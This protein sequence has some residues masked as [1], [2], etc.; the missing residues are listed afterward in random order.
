DRA[1]E[2]TPSPFT[3]PALTLSESDAALPLEV[4]SLKLGDLAKLLNSAVASPETR[5]FYA[6]FMSKPL[7]RDAW[8]RYPKDKDGLALQKALTKD[9]EFAALFELFSRSDRFQYRL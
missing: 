6:A 8:R 4:G 9:R 1:R 2:V 7:L 5:A 3:N